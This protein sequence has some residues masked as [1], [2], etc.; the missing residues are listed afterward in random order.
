VLRFSLESLRRRCAGRDQRTDFTARV[1][2]SE[3][4]V[5]LG[6]RPWSRRFGATRRGFRRAVVWRR[7][8][9]TG[10]G[11]KFMPGILAPPITR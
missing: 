6:G 10:P 11:G 7:S 9:H 8:V 1:I 4:I 5:I 3:Q 2:P